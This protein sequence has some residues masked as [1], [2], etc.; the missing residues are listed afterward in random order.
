MRHPF[1][2]AGAMSIILLVMLA[3]GCTNKEAQPTTNRNDNQQGGQTTH[4]DAK[5][6]ADRGL[7]TLAKLVNEQNYRAMGFESVAEVSTAALGEPIRVLMV[8]LDALRAYQ[9]GSDPN[10]LLSDV[11]QS[12]YPVMVRDQVRSTITVSQVDAGRWTAVS[13]GNPH[14]ARQTVQARRAI[15]AARQTA[16]GAS[17]TPL[18]QQTPS[19]QTTSSPRPSPTTT[20]SAQTTASPQA[21]PVQQVAVPDFLVHVAALNLR[22]M[23]HRDAS[24]KLML[25]PLEDVPSY[26]LKAGDALPAETVFAALVPFARQYNELPM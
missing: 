8:K 25:T 12:V 16:P 2:V 17:V 26:N 3:Q 20:P 22:F 6:A 5:S 24:G 1:T 9:P 11:P 19:T 21:T 14:L 18:T 4:A 15:S 23:A 13:F 10:L 7:A